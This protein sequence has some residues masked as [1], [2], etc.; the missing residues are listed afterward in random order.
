V[1]SPGGR[2]R[3]VDDLWP[4]DARRELVGPLSHALILARCGAARRPREWA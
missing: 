3:V 4:G 2:L 1:D